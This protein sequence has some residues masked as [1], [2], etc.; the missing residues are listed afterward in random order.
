[1]HNISHIYQATSKI[2]LVKSL[3]YFVT[4]RIAK[5]VFYPPA[6]DNSGLDQNE[7][8]FN[9]QLIIFQQQ[10]RIRRRATNPVLMEEVVDRLPHS[11]GTFQ[12]FNIRRGVDGNSIDGGL[13]LTRH[14]IGNN[15]IIR[16]HK[17]IRGFTII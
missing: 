15:R 17:T 4:Q 5:P 12:S 14:G 8:V 1:M 6:G 16:K 10:N 7:P 2:A 9:L 11:I 13:D 3:C